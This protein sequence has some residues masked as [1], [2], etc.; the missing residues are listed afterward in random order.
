M[1]ELKKQGMEQKLEKSC[2]RCKKNTWHVD[3]K[4]ILQHP[5]YSIIVVNRF[6]YINNSFTTDRCSIPMDMTVVL[7][8]QKFSLQATIDHHGPSTYSGNK[9]ASINCCKGTF[10]CNDSKVT[11][12]EMVITK[13]SS[14]AYVVMYELINGFQTNRR[15]GVLITPMAG[16]SSP[17]H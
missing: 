16:T 1:Q 2:F 4:Y 12:F 17:S 9:P 3:S 5:K 11:A 8:L 15:M 10:H 7:G 6:R 13:T 14:T